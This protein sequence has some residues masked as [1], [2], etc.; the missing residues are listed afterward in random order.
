MNLRIKFLI[1]FF[2][3]SVIINSYGQENIPYYTLKVDI[4]NYDLNRLSIKEIQQIKTYKETVQS[5]NKRDSIVTYSALEYVIK[6][7]SLN[8]TKTVFFDMEKDYAYNAN[9]KGIILYD[10]NKLSKLNP[11]NPEENLYP[12]ISDKDTIYYNYYEN[13]YQYEDNHLK[14]IESKIPNRYFY[15]ASMLK[16]SKPKDLLDKNY[17]ENKALNLQGWI[18]T[19][20][21][22]KRY[23]LNKKI[24]KLVSKVVEKFDNENNTTIVYKLKYKK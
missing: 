12:F 13:V 9:R 15:E 24:V 22:Y 10:S 19:K 1:S 23:F 3:F 4:I 16:K 21:Y 11:L 17:F 5:I 7:D 8:H 6:Y 2:F 20:Y 14:L 18:T